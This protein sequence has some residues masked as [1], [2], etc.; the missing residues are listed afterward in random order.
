M[1][2]RTVKD[3]RCGHCNAIIT[4]D[5]DGLIAHSLARHGESRPPRPESMA[6]V[7]K[8][9]SD[10]DIMGFMANLMFGRKRGAQKR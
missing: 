6:R 1:N 3:R 8:S 5:A 2:R 9:L 7:R 10:T 4:T